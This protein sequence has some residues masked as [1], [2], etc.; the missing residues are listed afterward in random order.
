MRKVFQEIL[1]FLALFGSL[2]TLVCCAIPALLVLMGFGAALAGVVAAVPQITILS[3]Y[4]AFTFSLAAFLIALAWVARWLAPSP[5]R[6]DA[7]H[8]DSASTCETAHERGLWVLVISSVLTA[9][10]A[11]V[12]FVLPAV[13]Y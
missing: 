4:K 11:L 10:G 7:G 13:L 12:A 6:C 3:E 8:A 2:G 5:V 1:S 9:I